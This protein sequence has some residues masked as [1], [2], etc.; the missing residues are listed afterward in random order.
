[1][2]QRVRSGSAWRARQLCGALLAVAIAVAVGVADRGRGA[3]TVLAI[4]MLVVAVHLAWRLVAYVEI[5]A[6]GLRVLRLGRRR[7]GWHE[8]A[9]FE[10]A[11]S[12]LPRRDWRRDY[13][14]KM[15]LTTGAVIR[16]PAPRTDSGADEEFRAALSLLRSHLGAKPH[17]P[18]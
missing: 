14:V 7:F 8:L 6:D 1:M 18:A 10:L 2:R 9:A 4:V 5:D 15:R 13:L 16:L 11:E 17:V 3:G 12:M